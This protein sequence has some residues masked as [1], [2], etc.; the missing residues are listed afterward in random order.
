[1]EDFSALFASLAEE[2]IADDAFCDTVNADLL[3]EGEDNNARSLVGRIISTKHVSRDA[4]IGMAGFYWKVQGKYE[5]EVF[6]NNIFLFRFASLTDRKR[7][8]E[9]GPW[10][11]DSNLLILK[12]SDAFA[13]PAATTFNLAEFWV[14]IHKIPMLCMSHSWGFELGKSIGTVRDVDLNASGDCC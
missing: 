5:I 10:V 9:G 6:G 4:V 8:L 7:V 12:E 3:A 13:D 1:M 14:Q 2:G 11:F